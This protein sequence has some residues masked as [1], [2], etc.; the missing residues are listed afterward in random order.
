ME[1]SDE[2]ETFQND[3]SLH[4]PILKIERI[5]VGF[6]DHKQEVYKLV[7]AM[8]TLFHYTQTDKESVE[9]YS[10]N[11]TSLWDTAEAFGASYGIHR[12]LVEG[13]LLF[14]PGRIADVNNIS[15]IEQT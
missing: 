9:G 14:K 13:W 2:W 10:H 12:L 7:Q 5:C 11:L 1:S 15:D 6:D 4:Q 3:Q 8:K